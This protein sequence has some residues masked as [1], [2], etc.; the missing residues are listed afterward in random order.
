MSPPNQNEQVIFE[1]VPVQEQIDIKK[2]ADG[3]FYLE[4][5][6]KTVCRILTYTTTYKKKT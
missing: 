5:P 2:L 4:F 1:T 6:E 3:G